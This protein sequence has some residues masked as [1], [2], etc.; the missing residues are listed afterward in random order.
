[1]LGAFGGEPDLA[2]FHIEFRALLGVR[3]AGE[4]GVTETLR[5]GALP[6][7]AMFCISRSFIS[8]SRVIGS[9]SVPVSDRAALVGSANS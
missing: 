6:G 9:A 3:A 8:L 2:E 4:F 1:M 5:I 7:L